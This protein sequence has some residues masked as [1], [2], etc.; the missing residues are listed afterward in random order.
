MTEKK[1]AAET[2]SQEEFFLAVKVIEKYCEQDGMSWAVVTDRTL[3][4]YRGGSLLCLESAL[5][6][7]NQQC[8][9]DLA[10][11]YHQAQMAA[12]ARK[13]VDRDGNLAADDAAV[14]KALN[15]DK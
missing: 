11:R 5:L 1:Q 3:G 2:V 7:A 9:A 12:D 15:M 8:H 14:I 6:H 13:Q 4:Q 10:V